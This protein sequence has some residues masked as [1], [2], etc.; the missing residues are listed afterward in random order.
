M[1]DYHKSD[2]VTFRHMLARK[3]TL[4]INNSLPQNR[5]PQTSEA[6]CTS[7]RNHNRKGYRLG[8]GKK[9]QLL[10]PDFICE[11]GRGSQPGGIGDKFSGQEV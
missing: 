9:P 1:F 8:E 3:M 11:V 5:Q 4:L 2:V 6:F 7:R 10:D